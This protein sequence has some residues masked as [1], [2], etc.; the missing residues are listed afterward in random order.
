MSK[1]SPL[2]S[3]SFNVKHQ[4]GV[5][6]VS[7]AHAEWNKERIS[8][9]SMFGKSNSGY[10]ASLK[11]ESPFKDYKSINIALSQQVE[12]SQ[13]LSTIDID[14]KPMKRI[15]S[16]LSLKQPVQWN[17]LEAVF[18]I[19][20]PIPGFERCGIE[21]RNIK[22]DKVQSMVKFSWNNDFIQADILAADKSAE[23]TRDLTGRF[24]V[25]STLRKLTS[26][27]V[28][29][30][31]G[32]N[33]EKF[34]NSINFEHNGDAYGYQGELRHSR[35][36]WQLQNSGKVTFNAPSKQV[37]SSWS[38]R[39]TAG[40]LHTS[41]RFASGSSVVDF[42]ASGAQSMSIPQGYLDFRRCL[43]TPFADVSDIALTISHEHRFG[44][45]D[46]KIH[47][48]TKGKRVVS[49][50]NKY[51]RNNGIAASSHEF[52]CH[53][54]TQSLTLSSK[55]QSFPLNGQVEYMYNK[56][57]VAKI[58]GEFDYP[59]SGL[60]S[61]N[62]QVTSQIAGFENGKI[63]MDQS[64]ERG[65]IVTRS[66]ILLPSGNK[67]TMENRGQWDKKKSF[68]TV[69]NT[70]YRDLQRL[71]VGAEF[72]A[73]KHEGTASQ[74]SSHGEMQY[75]KSKKYQI[76]GNY[77]N[78]AGDVTIKSPLHD[79]LAASFKH[80]GDIS[81]FD[82][83]LEGSYGR[84]KKYEMDA[85]Y[86]QRSGTLKIKTPFYDDVSASFS[87]KGEP[88]NFVSQA[89]FQYGESK[90]YEAL[91]KLSLANVWTGSMSFGSPITEDFTT[92][93]SH[94]G[95]LSDFDTKASLTE[96]GKVTYEGSI[97]FTNGKK[98]MGSAS[99]KTPFH[100]DLSAT[101]RHSG[102]FSGYKKMKGIL[103]FSGNT[104]SFKTTAR[105]S[106][107]KEYIAGNIKMSIRP[108]FNA[109]ISI[110]TPFKGLKKAG[111]VLSHQGQINNFKSH[112]EITL[113]KNKLYNADVLFA[114]DPKF[115]ASIAL[116]TPFRGLEKTELSLTHDGSYRN[117]NNQVNLYF[118]KKRVSSSLKI[119]LRS[120]MSAE[121]V[122]QTPFKNYEML[123][124]T[125]NHKGHW[126]NFKF[127]IEGS[128]GTSNK[129]AGDVG[130]NLVDQVLANLKL[131]SPLKSMELLKAIFSHD[132]T[133]NNFR[134]HGEFE[135]NN[136]KSE[137]DVHFS[138]LVNLEGRFIIKSPYVE[139]LEG[140]FVHDTSP[141]ATSAALKY[142]GQNLMNGKMTFGVSPLQ[143]SL[144]FNS[145]YTRPLK[146]SLR[147]NA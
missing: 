32:D 61:G 52:S 67:I 68:N 128:D 42:R 116:E 37:E 60:M 113:G 111:I 15:S 103:N 141:M 23:S 139:T 84:G 55:Y 10:S 44:M 119:D 81:D 16:T 95:S 133:F 98:V 48:S 101:F 122:L 39:N 34:E 130:M 64:N 35:N 51:K 1:N 114:T 138:S 20:S 147:H 123:Q 91:A 31:H 110:E 125:V 120:D 62:I 56:K 76:T 144:N 108:N 41:F 3:G 71:V 75:G 127:H 26:L 12:N 53:G 105:A 86:S 2:G 45:I 132:G 140:T 4:G 85:K 57:S 102:D 18:D 69:L 30:K 66:S 121:M 80:K 131:T 82:T 8:V 49:L 88:T 50:T 21:V 142:G 97:A 136:A 9:D 63:S 73:I 117:F 99:L 27:S 70:P 22:G 11:V 146:V 96:A 129:F 93:F 112:G 104:K 58:A 137:I 24:S 25:K 126:N 90:K 29:A 124:G 43:Q 47:Y 5:N 107:G 83:H 74:F 65:E 6:Y 106:I 118:N 38:H 89:E 77:G 115:S 109:D 59:S 17:D 100:R 143:G 46:N 19:K 134:S 36:G 28:S 78:M 7:H 13:S 33:G 92:S 145:I 54:N 135:L 40:E 79:D 72:S 87:H 14:W 94:E